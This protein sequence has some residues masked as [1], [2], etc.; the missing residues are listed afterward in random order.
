MD[1]LPLP[2][3]WRLRTPSCLVRGVAVL[4]DEGGVAGVTSLA[5]LLAPGVAPVEGLAEILFPTGLPALPMGFSTVMTDSFTH[6]T[7]VGV[8]IS[9]SESSD[10]QSQPLATCAWSHLP[11]VAAPKFL[12][13]METIQEYSVKDP[14][15]FAKIWSWLVHEV[16]APPPGSALFLHGLGGKLQDPGLCAAVRAVPAGLPS[17]YVPLQHLLTRLSV[18]TVLLVTRLVLLE[19]KVLF[20]G[21]SV[22]MLTSACEAFSSILLFPLAWVHCYNP[23][24][25]STDY[26][27]T[28]PPFLFG[29]LREIILKETFA[30]SND[31]LS[32]DL[33]GIRQ[34]SNSPT[35]HTPEP[36][37][38]D[39]TVLD[40]D[41]G[42]VY[43]HQMANELPALPEAAQSRLRFS[44]TELRA[45]V[46]AKEDLWPGSKVQST[47]EFFQDAVQK[48]YLTFMADLLGDVAS[49]LGP[50]CEIA[51]AASVLSS[52]QEGRFLSGVSAKDKPFFESFVQTNA[53]LAYLQTLHL[54]GTSQSPFAEALR[55]LGHRKDVVSFSEVPEP[56]VPKMGGERGNFSAAE[57]WVKNRVGR[58]GW[59]AK[60][61]VMELHLRWNSTADSLEHLGSMDEKIL[62]A[63]VK[64]V[65]LEEAAEKESTGGV[66]E[67]LEAVLVETQGNDRHL[68]EKL[69]CDMY[70]SRTLG[71]LQVSEYRWSF[72]LLY[73]VV[74]RQMG[75]SPDFLLRCLFS[76][77]CPAAVPTHSLLHLM[78]SLDPHRLGDLF[79]ETSRETPQPDMEDEDED[80]DGEIQVLG[81]ENLQAKVAE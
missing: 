81:M 25:P 2:E 68:W 14:S 31:L 56:P 23:L 54:F 47:E 73:F 38:R 59:S 75:A 55:S 10:G 53:F 58:P 50:P 30:D 24:L 76:I 35:S 46:E 61:A 41:T 5:E 15:R 18:S 60:E 27:A 57:I 71:A 19:Q 48:M 37:E 78:N 21:S 8:Q 79:A 12:K 51:T 42:D 70:R 32:S 34:R 74:C 43:F 26:L 36:A 52:F 80:N 6:R 22:A 49:S 29:C 65:P 63:S 7:Y 66:L 77:E 4:K 45:E 72:V 17:V 28:P 64:T 9:Y 44:L 13:L 67:A 69:A 40:L 16:P 39:F 11:E 1:A 62:L 33:L 20:V 3:L